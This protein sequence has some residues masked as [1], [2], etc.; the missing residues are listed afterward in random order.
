MNKG[1]IL[2]IIAITAAFFIRFHKEPNV[3][4][5]SENAASEV[6]VLANNQ[7][8]S[9][10]SRSVKGRSP[11][12]SQYARHGSPPPKTPYPTGHF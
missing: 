9:G 8:D 11:G 3:S 10:H 5:V 2:V 6:A 4:N 12:S 1:N 7:T